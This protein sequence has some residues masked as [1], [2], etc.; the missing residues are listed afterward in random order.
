MHHP[1]GQWDTNIDC[2]LTDKHGKI[3]I[4]DVRI[5]YSQKWLNNHWRTI[6]SAYRNAPF[7]EYYADDLHDNSIQA[8]DI[9]I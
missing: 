4:K 3:A 9:F 7:F 2:A 6:T 8:T 5:D 1:H